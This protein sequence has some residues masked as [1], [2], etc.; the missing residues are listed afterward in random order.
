MGIK[1]L[2][3]LGLFLLLTTLTGCPGGDEDDC[4][5]Y[6]GST[7]VDNLIALTP[8]QTVYNQ[9]DIITIKAEIAAANNYFGGPLNLFD[10]TNDYQ[11]RLVTTS[12]YLFA[13]NQVTYVKGSIEAYEGGWSNV[14]YNSS[15]GNYELEI[16]VQLNKIGV[17]SFFTDDSFEFQGASKCNRYRIDSNISGWNSQGKIEFTVQ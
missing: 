6:G 15:T 16:K 13:G 9:G 11:A 5:D 12:K 14:P 1:T 8:L 3:F 2:K 7:R 17:Y 10:A 4:F